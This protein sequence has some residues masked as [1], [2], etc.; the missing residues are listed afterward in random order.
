MIGEGE[1]ERAGIML[2]EVRKYE[3]SARVLRLELNNQS[4]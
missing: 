2:D 3:G 1:M 4:V